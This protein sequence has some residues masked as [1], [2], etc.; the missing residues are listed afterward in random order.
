MLPSASKVRLDHWSG[1]RDV[2]GRGERGRSGLG[3]A[4]L[5]CIKPGSIHPVFPVEALLTFGNDFFF[6][7]P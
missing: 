4:Q 1:D 2:V 5:A 7:D 6:N 3:S